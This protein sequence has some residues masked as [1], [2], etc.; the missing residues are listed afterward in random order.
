MK[1]K[2]QKCRTGLDLSIG[3]YLDCWIVVVCYCCDLMW[4]S[5]CAVQTAVIKEE[6]RFH[7]KR[8][9]KLMW[10]RL[11]GH[12]LFFIWCAQIN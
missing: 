5:S 6:K 3:K 7:C 4:E 11:Q 9:G 8:E 12:M 2:L 1:R 10:I